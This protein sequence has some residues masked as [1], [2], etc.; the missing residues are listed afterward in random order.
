MYLRS[1][2]LF[3]HYCCYFVFIIGVREGSGSGVQGGRIFFV[4]AWS[5]GKRSLAE[6]LGCSIRLS[7]RPA[8]PTHLGA[9]EADEAGVE[10][11][12]GCSTRLWYRRSWIL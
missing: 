1:E 9:T 12:V 6:P 5:G 8:G 2:C 10:E 7:F 4:M 3:L 11:A